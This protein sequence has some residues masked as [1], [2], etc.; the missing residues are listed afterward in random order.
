MS[1]QFMLKDE[2][3]N[4]TTYDTNSHDDIVKMVAYAIAND[5]KIVGVN[6]KTFEFNENILMGY[7]NSAQTYLRELFEYMLLNNINIITSNKTLQDFANLKGYNY[8]SL[9]ILLRRV[10]GNS[11]DYK[12][13]LNE[14]FAKYKNN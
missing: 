13:K 6:N 8:W 2:Q 11:G 14:L 5:Y 9:Y 3:L 12:D 4:E 10:L 7:S 1:I